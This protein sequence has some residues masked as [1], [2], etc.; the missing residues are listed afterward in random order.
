[1]I[2]AGDLWNEIAEQVAAERQ[3]DD[4]TVEQRLEA[5]GGPMVGLLCGKAGLQPTH[6]DLDAIETMIRFQQRAGRAGKVERDG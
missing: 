6:R 2:T 5:L 4:S 1:M 3:G